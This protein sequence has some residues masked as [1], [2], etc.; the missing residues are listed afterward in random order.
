MCISGN[1]R[2]DA[3]IITIGIVTL[4]LSRRGEGSSRRLTDAVS[5]Y[6]KLTHPPPLSRLSFSHMRRLSLRQGL[7]I[8]KSLYGTACLTGDFRK[9]KNNLPHHICGRLFCIKLNKVLITQ[10]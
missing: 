10:R 2:S 5:I 9:H 4:S 1:T 3:R 7:L 8:G 6:I